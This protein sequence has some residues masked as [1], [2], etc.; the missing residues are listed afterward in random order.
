M[1]DELVVLDEGAGVEE[2][3]EALAGGEFA[4]GVLGFDTGGTTTEEGGGEEG[5]K[6]GGE[7]GRRRGE[8]RSGGGLRNEGGEGTGQEWRTWLEGEKQAGWRWSEGGQH[9]V[10]EH[11]CR[12]KIV[13]CS[14]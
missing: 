4:F 10:G 1:S 14:S 9:A 8:G 11:S 7:R 5:R 6:A 3:G 12:E 2:E 13:W